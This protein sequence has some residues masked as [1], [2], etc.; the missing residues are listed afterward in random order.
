MAAADVLTEKWTGKPPANQCRRIEKIAVNGSDDVDPQSVVSITL[1]TNDPENDPLKV[2]W[3]LQKEAEVF[4]EGGD[5]EEVPPEF[6]DAILKGDLQ[7]AQIKLPRDGGNY[8]VFA[9]VAEGFSFRTAVRES[10]ALK[11]GHSW[12]GFIRHAKEPE[13]P[14]VLLED[15][16]AL[17]G[18]VLA[19]LGVTLTLA[20][21]DG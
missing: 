13:L 15:L 3:K 10:R 21:D 20:T 6:P 1:K 17:V 11:G 4:G 7:G 18:L 9:I 12:A 8:R 16:A 14:V 19:L 2:R 5:A